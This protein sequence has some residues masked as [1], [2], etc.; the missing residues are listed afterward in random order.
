MH[1][2]SGN[3]IFYF[4]KKNGICIAE[5]KLEA[6]LAK[7]WNIFIGFS[8]LVLV[9]LYDNEVHTNLLVTLKKGSSRYGVI[10]G[11]FPLTWVC[12]NIQQLYKVS[13]NLFS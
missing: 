11:I 9:A 5:G 8:F 6:N 4:R 7:I 10:Q 3:F 13:L 12:S 2:F 1:C